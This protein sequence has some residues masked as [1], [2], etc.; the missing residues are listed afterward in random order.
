MNRLCTGESGTVGRTPLQVAHPMPVTE[1]KTSTRLLRAAEAE[2]KELRAQRAR[3]DAAHNATLAQLREIERALADI[4]E[5]KRL[6]D[7]LAP[8]STNAAVMTSGSAAERT[9]P[10]RV[11][12]DAAAAGADDAA[13]TAAH[14]LRGPAI[15]ETAVRLLVR[16]GGIEA[17][18][19]RQWFELLKSEGYAVAGKDSLA[20]FLTQISRSPAVRKGTQAGVY[21]LDRDAPR[22]LARDVQRLQAELLELAGRTPSTADLA[23]IRA[24]R[25]QLTSAIGQAER[26]LEEAQRVLA[27]DAVDASTPL[28]V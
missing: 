20:V 13:A 2:R 4:D 28:A 5:R 16:R 11:G 24:R 27:E 17:L 25:E 19:Y 7:Q 26:A 14:V 12:H 1:L 18:H 23:E 9:R 8:R 21:E 3:L 15:R 10:G 22:R 6:L